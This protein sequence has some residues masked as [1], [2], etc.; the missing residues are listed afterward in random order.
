MCRNFKPRFH[1]YPYLPNNN[2]N[3]ENPSFFQMFAS[4]LTL[5]G[6]VKIRAVSLGKY[7]SAIA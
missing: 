6:A 1:L 7:I 2:P 5:S 4:H 3:L